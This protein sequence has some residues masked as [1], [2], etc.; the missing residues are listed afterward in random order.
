MGVEDA[1]RTIL[2]LGV[3]QPMNSEKRKS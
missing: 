1:F 2:S 3:A